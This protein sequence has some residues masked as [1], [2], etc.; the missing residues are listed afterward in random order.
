M[1]KIVKTWC[2]N[3]KEGESYLKYNKYG[4]I[5]KRIPNTDLY[6]CIGSEKFTTCNDVEI[7]YKNIL[8]L[9]LTN[10]LIYDRIKY[11][12]NQIKQKREVNNNG[13]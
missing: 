9:C 1:I 6:I 10:I 11:K 3:T 13:N 4:K 12:L 5:V 2:E 7:I 8:S